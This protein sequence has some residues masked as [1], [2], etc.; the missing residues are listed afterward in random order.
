MKRAKPRRERSW[1]QAVRVLSTNFPEGFD[2][3]GGEV[4]CTNGRL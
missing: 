3:V 4:L 2:Q 1:P